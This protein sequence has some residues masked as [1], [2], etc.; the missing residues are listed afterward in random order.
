L[1]LLLS[2]LSKVSNFL[3][4]LVAYFALSGA[5]LALRGATL[6]LRLNRFLLIDNGARRLKLRWC[7]LLS[8]HAQI[9]LQAYPV[10]TH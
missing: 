8:R 6:A 9:L 3:V 2:F 7:V 10:R 4:S 5:T 1:G